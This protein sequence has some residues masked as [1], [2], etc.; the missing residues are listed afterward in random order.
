MQ[1]DI[2]I[3]NLKPYQPTLQFTPWS[4]DLFIRVSFLILKEH[5]VMQAFRRIELIV[6]IAISVIPDNHL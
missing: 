6:H 2:L 3:R 5:T 1:I 4:L